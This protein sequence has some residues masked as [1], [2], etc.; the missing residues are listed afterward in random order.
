MSGYRLSPINTNLKY[1]HKN[2]R[3][4]DLWYVYVEMLVSTSENPT[5]LFVKGTHLPSQSKGSGSIN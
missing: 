2:F 1:D 5:E 3:G 4:E